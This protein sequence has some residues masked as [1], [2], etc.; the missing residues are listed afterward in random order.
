MHTKEL[1]TLSVDIDPGILCN[2]DFSFPMFCR[3]VEMGWISTAQSLVTYGDPINVLLGI[4]VFTL[5]FRFMPVITLH[6]DKS[7]SHWFPRWVF[8]NAESIQLI[9]ISNVT[10]FTS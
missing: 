8:F 2:S 10:F 5:T 4:L 6:T 1:H 3:T 7:V 9:P